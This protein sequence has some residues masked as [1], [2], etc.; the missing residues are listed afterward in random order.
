MWDAS[1]CDFCG[2][3]LVECRYAGYDRD[4]AVKEIKLLVEGKEPRI[5]LIGVSPAWPV[6]MSAR[7]V[8]IRPI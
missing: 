3:C 7:P 4:K 6:P 5:F 1:K 8:P 2:D